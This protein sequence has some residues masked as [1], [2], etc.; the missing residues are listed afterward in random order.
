M[1]HIDIPAIWVY[2]AI[3]S[4]STIDHNDLHAISEVITLVSWCSHHKCLLTGWHEVME[5][6]SPQFQTLKV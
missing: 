3:V 6:Y 1:S 4:A 2:M 5:T